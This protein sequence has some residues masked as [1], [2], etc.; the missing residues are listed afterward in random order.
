MALAEVDRLEALVLLDN[1]T[2]SLSTN[3]PGVRPELPRL[4]AR[5][6]KAWSGEGMAIAHHGL[7]VLV[8]A[9][10]G[11]VP[12]TVL[13]D[14]GP[15]GAA[16]TRNAARLGADLGAVDAVVLSHGHWDHAGGLLAA[17]EAVRKA[18]GEAVPVHLHPGMFGH[19]GVKLADGTI[20]PFEDVPAP[21]RIA[22]AGGRPGLTREPQVLAGGA[23]W[24]SGEVPRRTPY[25]QGFPNHLQRTAAGAWEPDP[26]IMDERFLAANVKGKGVVVFS[27]CSHAG[28]VNVLTHARELFP[29]VPLHGVLGG[30]HLAGA[31]PEKVV[32][33]TVADV[34]RMGLRRVAPGHCTGWRAVHAL[35]AA[36]GEDVVA[37]SAVGKHY[38]F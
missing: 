29:G 4:V 3:P 1:A 24:L 37:P 34:A 15:E 6:M 19:R 17:V 30:L 16:F 9:W 21:E 26:L 28:I 25:E 27:A 2:D 5:G 33:D 18:R 38:A 36:L 31:G 22:Q 12:H 13:F 23:F 11:E 8:T 14:A 10:Q 7:S 32:R 35:A 20:V